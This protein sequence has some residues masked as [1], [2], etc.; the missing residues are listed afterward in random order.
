MIKRHFLCS[1]DKE[2]FLVIDKGI[3]NKRKGKTFYE[4]S[5]HERGNLR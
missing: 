3:K 4:T 2:V 5:F 1:V